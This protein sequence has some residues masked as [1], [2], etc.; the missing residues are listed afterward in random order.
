MVKISK[1]SL[2]VKRCS[3]KTETFVRF[4]ELANIEK[5]KKMKKKT[6]EELVK[7][8]ERLIE[9][10]LYPEIEWEERQKDSE[11]KQVILRFKPLG[12]DSQFCIS[13]PFHINAPI[14]YIEHQKENMIRKLGLMYFNK[15]IEYW[16]KKKEQEEKKNETIQ[17]SRMVKQNTISL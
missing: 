8:N 3:P 15:G 7:E 5:E 1:F 12:T 11:M 9:K 16:K 13:E 14:E 2:V 10:I 17:N 4:K 6:Y